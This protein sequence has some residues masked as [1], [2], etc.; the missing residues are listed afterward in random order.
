MAGCVERLRAADLVP[1]VLTLHSLPPYSISTDGGSSLTLYEDT[2]MNSTIDNDVYTPLDFSD[3]PFIVDDDRGRTLQRSFWNVTPTGDYAADSQLGEDYA[4][5][6]LQYINETEFTPLLGWI[7]EEMPPKERTSQ[8]EF[9]FFA[10][11][12]YLA[13]RGMNTTGRRMQS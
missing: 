1:V 12:T 10:T 6:T 5:K 9:G 7:L 4:L 11:L 3:L 2:A 8:I 13:M